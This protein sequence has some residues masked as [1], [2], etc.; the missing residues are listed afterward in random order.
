MINIAQPI[1][2]MLKVY[3]KMA[4]MNQSQEKNNVWKHICTDFMERFGGW[5]AWGNLTGWER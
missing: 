1:E 4:L 2:N 5:E 3:A